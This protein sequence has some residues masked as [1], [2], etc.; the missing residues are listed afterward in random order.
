MTWSSVVKQAALGVGGYRAIGAARRFP[1]LAVL[2]YHGILA[3]DTPRAT[4][5]FAP[6]HVGASTFRAHCAMLAAH[7]DCM[8]LDDACAVWAGTLPMPPRGVVVTFDDGHRGL[9]SHALPSLERYRVPA[10]VFVCT[11]PVVSGNAFWFDAMAR[12]DGESAVAAAKSWP[13]DAWR[14]RVPL[15]LAAPDDPVAPLTLD[16]VQ[17]LAAHPLITLGAHT[18]MH[19]I[20]ARAPRDVQAREIAE[21]VQTVRQWTGRSSIAFAFPNGR[22]GVDFDDTAVAE[23]ERTGS[24][25]AFTT[26]E[27][28]AAR[29]EPALARSRFMMLASVSAAELAHRLFVSWPRR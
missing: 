27:A 26:H 29:R 22:P 14:A 10:V 16:A 6:L 21:S 9:V 19:P 28:F 13:Y 12:R 4:V 17:R 1:G 20:L 23:V 15:E 24:P 3:D 7:C 18:V 11:G 2:A 8:T 5:P 25:V